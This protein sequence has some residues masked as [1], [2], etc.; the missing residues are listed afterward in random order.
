MVVGKV[1]GELFERFGL[2]AVLGELGAGILLGNL[3]LLHF[4]R[5]EPLKTNPTIAALA[6]IGVIILLMLGLGN[7]A[8]KSGLRWASAA[9]S[10]WWVIGGMVGS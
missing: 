10:P 2:P 3:L 8:D 5:A 1:G 9:L 6:E 4:Y 7:I